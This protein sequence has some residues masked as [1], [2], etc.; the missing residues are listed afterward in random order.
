MREKTS[1]IRALVFDWDGVF[2]DGS[3]GANSHSNF[4]DVDTMGVN[5]MR[6]AY[7]RATAKNIKVAVISG[8]DNPSALTW[9]KRDNLH[10]L[11]SN[12]KNKAVA[13]QHFCDNAK[14]KPHEVAYFFDDIVDLPIA[15]V[16]GLRF[17]V[18]RLANPLFL[19]YVEHKEL[20]DYISAAQGNEHA[21]REFAEIFTALLDQ[22]FAVIESRAAFDSRYQQFDAERRAVSL[23]QWREQNDSLQQIQ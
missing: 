10:A 23:H 13:F 12:C 20:A 6:Y 8:E 3:K 1:A 4:S 21:V 17:A 7:Y 15:K 2:N 16:A 22:H 14:L 18:G 9:A 19:K 5:M 11:Y